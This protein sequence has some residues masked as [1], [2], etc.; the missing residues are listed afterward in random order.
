MTHKLLP[1]ADKP[2]TVTG[3]A[4]GPAEPDAVTVGATGAGEGPDVLIVC[5]M[6][7]SPI[8]V[9]GVHSFTKT[10]YLERLVKHRL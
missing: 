1:S 9:L 7:S 5:D 8:V 4:V 10:V 2:G 6:A 3:A